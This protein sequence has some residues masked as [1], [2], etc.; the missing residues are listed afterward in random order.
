MLSFLTLLLIGI[1]LSMDTFSLSIIYGTLNLEKK[2][3][4][5]LSIIVGMFHFLMPLLGN[6]IGSQLLNKLPFNP[7]IVVGAIF[8]L[9]AIQMILQ[10]EEVMDLTKLVAFFVFGF[11]VSL[12]SF[13]VGIGISRIT[14]YPLSAYFIFSITSFIFTFLGLMFGKSLSNKFGN[15]ATFIGAVI[16]GVLGLIYIF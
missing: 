9:I 11:T 16:L 1:S 2:K 5:L 14:Q 10:K 3:I 6:M 15:K 4:Y 12:D 13:S 7:D 8:I